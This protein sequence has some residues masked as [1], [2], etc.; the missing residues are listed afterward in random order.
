M[1]FKLI[2]FSFGICIML[3][4]AL[5]NF[6]RPNS[7]VVFPSMVL[8]ILAFAIM[9]VIAFVFK[10]VIASNTALNYSVSFILSYSLLLLVLWR[11]NAGELVS[12]IMKIHKGKDFMS[13]LL[14]FI[15]SNISMLI[16]ILFS[17]K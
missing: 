9:L 3:T 17:K 5:A 13:M 11:I 6:Y 16:Y 4:I 12:T 2:G 7:S 14:P 8:Q 15:V 10:K 1:I